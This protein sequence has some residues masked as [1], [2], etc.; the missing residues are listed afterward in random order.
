MLCFDIPDEK[1]KK[2]TEKAVF[3]ST[4]S[5]LCSLCCLKS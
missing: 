5:M 4:V 2:K 3:L 1:F